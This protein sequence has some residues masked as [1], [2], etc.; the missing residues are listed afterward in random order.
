VQ[1]RPWR[2]WCG[3]KTTGGSLKQPCLVRSTQLV[4]GVLGDRGTTDPDRRGSSSGIRIGPGTRRA[5][6]TDYALECSRD[7]RAID[8]FK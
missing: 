1:N 2:M 7:I 4:A 6:K 8:L 3:I 5:L